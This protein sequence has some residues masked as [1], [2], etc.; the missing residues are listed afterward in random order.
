MGAQFSS[1]TEASPRHLE[2]RPD[3]SVLAV[4]LQAYREADLNGPTLF[5]S[6]II[7]QHKFYFFPKACINDIEY[8]RRKNSTA[9]YFEPY[10]LFS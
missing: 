5:D 8:C 2:T 9:A 6:S 7:F 1:V 4:D 3:R 10:V